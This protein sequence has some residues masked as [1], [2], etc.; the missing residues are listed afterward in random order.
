MPHWEFLIQREDDRA[1][2]PLTSRKL[3]IFEGNYR[4]I[5]NTSMSNS[6]VHTQIFYQNHEQPTQLAQDH[7]QQISNEGLLVV[8]PFTHIQ[9]GTW[10]LNCN[11]AITKESGVEE[12]LCLQV[13]PRPETDEQE[14][15]PSAVEKNTDGLEDR[16]KAAVTVIH[17]HYPMVVSDVHPEKLI[18]SSLANLDH[19][20]TEIAPIVAQPVLMSHELTTTTSTTSPY[21]EFIEFP[22]EDVLDLSVLPVDQVFQPP[23]PF[24][25]ALQINLPSQEQI[26]VEKLT[27]EDDQF[28]DMSVVTDL[29]FSELFP[30]KLPID[31]Y[32]RHSYE[33]VVED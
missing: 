20:L 19:L 2:R 32:D 17:D 9:L 29:Q 18:A 21:S 5:A 7:A 14:T 10:H 6:A 23:D 1:W 33:V 24:A 15:P 11:V 3:E 12:Q 25:T 31:S 8:M 16:S 13:V 4:I 28:T 22:E 26:P 30:H 27:I